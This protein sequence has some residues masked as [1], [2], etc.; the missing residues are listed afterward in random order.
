GLDHPNIIRVL[1]CEEDSSRPYLVLEQFEGQ[2]LSA[3]LSAQPHLEQ[4]RLSEILKSAAS[5][6]DHV[7]AKGLIHNHLTPDSI[8]L[9]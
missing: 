1:S 3:V 4:A 7:H 9:S 8:V 2:L 6:L 5:A